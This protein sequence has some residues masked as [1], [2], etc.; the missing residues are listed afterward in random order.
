MLQETELHE[1][2]T[3]RLKKIVG[4]EWVSDFPEELF[5]YSYDM[6][7]HPPSTPEFVVMPKT[8]TEIQEIVKLANEFKISIV[9]FVTGANVGGLT[10]P[11]KGGMILDLKRMD[12]I[13]HINTHDMY[14]IV[15]PGVTFGH[16]SKFLKENY[17]QFRYCYPN[18]PPFTS[19]MANAL[20]GGLNNLS[21]KYGSMAEVINGIEAVLPTGELVKIGTC[22]C[23]DNMDLWWSRN[24]MP[25]LLGLFTNWQGMTGIVTKIGLQIWPNKPY[26]DWKFVLSN[27]LAATYKFCKKLAT[28]EI[29]NDL[30][31]MSLETIKMVL[32]LPYG[33][34]IHTPG[35]PHWAIVLDYA[36]NSQKE[37]EAKWELILET[38]K[39]LKK[40]DPKAV[41][42]SIDAAAKVYGHT[43]GDFKNLPFTI[44][45]MLEYGGNTWVGTYFTTK[46]E[47]VVQGVNKAFE[48]IKK[49]NFETCLYTR[50]MKGGHYFA[51]R[52]LLR[53]DKGKEGE[54]E[55]MRQLNHEL[56]E[57]LFEMGAFP[58]KTPAWA[59]EKIIKHCDPNWVML[60]HKIKKTLDPNNIFNPGRWGL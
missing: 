11:L 31:F 35:E 56:F 27:D 5:T 44:G 34:A 51:F 40:V 55:R 4:I 13:L 24:P 18:A 48:I 30:L 49:H 54:I 21:L 33:T 39:E 60:M 23:W 22:M 36:A 57:T 17:P 58:Y 25:D 43:F 42:S 50:F 47:T 2:V 20:L 6:T 14:V 59:A 41:I 37:F 9:P 7:E 45:G 1:T 52:F 38:F 29:L 16:I 8:V 10:I 28:M 15:E 53:F 19:I 32:G 12:Q 3:E 26:R 46:P